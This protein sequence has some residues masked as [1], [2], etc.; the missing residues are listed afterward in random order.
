[1][2][3][4]D[5]LKLLQKSVS[6]SLNPDACD[7]LVIENAKLFSQFLENKVIKEG[8]KAPSISFYDENLKIIHL[9]DLLKDKHIVLSFFRGTWCPYCNLELAALAKIYDA[10]KEK[11][12]QLI[13][14]SP[15]LHEFSG[16]ILQK[17]KIEFPTYAD[18]SNKAADKFGLAFKLPPAYRDIYKSLNI[19][20]NKLNGT[21]N[22]TLPIPATFIISKDGLITSTYI[23]ADYTKRMEPDD[24]LK[25]LDLLSS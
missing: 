25:Q 12:A 16:S 3:L 4:N 11:G 22:W 10:I 8:A 9:H 23:N 24:I 18:L 1:M 21:P 6:N 15:E 2:S 17:N 5:E 20:L 14:L 7:K 19:H 13:A